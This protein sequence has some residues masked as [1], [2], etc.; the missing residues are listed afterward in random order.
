MWSDSPTIEQS[1]V[2]MGIPISPWWTLSAFL[3]SPL[4]SYGRRHADERSDVIIAK[5]KG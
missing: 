3:G 5:D 1:P 4:H 2:P